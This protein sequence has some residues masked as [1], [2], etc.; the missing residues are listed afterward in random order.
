LDRDTIRK[1]VVDKI[2]EMLRLEANLE[3]EDKNTLEDLGAD[4]LDKVEIMMA[5]EEEFSFEIPDEEA[6]KLKTIG[7]II[8]YINEAKQPKQE[9]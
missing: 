3:I 8:D 6:E 1:H 5:L 4:S 2:A 7:Q 9:A